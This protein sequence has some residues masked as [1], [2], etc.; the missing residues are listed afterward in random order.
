MK[1]RLAMALSLSLSLATL[2]PH[3]AAGQPGDGGTGGSGTVR[4][5]LPNDFGIELLGRSIIYNF[6]YQRLVTPAL[7]LEA[8]IAGLGSGSTTDDEGGSLLFGSLGGRFYF[9]DKNASPFVTGGV[10]LLSAS[11]DAGPFGSD[12]ATATYGYS[13]LGFEFR[14]L[15]GFLFRGTAYGLVADGGYFIWPGLTLGYAF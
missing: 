7:G 13:G 2:L 3:P 11:T 1:A 9:V 10:V 5:A 8:T 14:S 6:S 12:Q 4:T 15:S